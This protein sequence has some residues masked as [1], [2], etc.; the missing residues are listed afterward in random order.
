M[1]ALRV[2]FAAAWSLVAAGEALAHDA[3]SGWAYD[4][5]C[6]S[7][8]DCAPIAADHVRVTAQGY[9]VS[10]PVG[11]HPMVRDGVVS[12]VV[13]YGATRPSGDGMFHACVLPGSQHLVCLYAPPGGV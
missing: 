6:C 5:A 2:A 11:A 7:N 1:G 12:R 3:P 8:R 4:P 9:A 13:S 10:L